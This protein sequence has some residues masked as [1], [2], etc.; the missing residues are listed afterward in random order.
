METFT[1]LTAIV[2]GISLKLNE[3]FGDEYTIYS[4]DVKQGLSRPCFFI[5]LLNPSSVIERGLTYIREN[6]YCI[7]FFPKST[8]EPKAECYQMLDKLYMALE[9]INVDDN[10]GRMGEQDAKRATSLIRG[11]RMLGEIHDG[12]LQFNVDY[13]V[14]VR[15]IYNPEMMQ[16]LE[17]IEFRTKTAR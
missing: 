6:T 10:S 5:K 1:P 9:Y 2:D 17:S 11:V 15:K 4:E 12:V 8:S 7:H 14:R 3:I 16:T 13:N